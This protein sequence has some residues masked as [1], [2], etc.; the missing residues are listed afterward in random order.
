P[1]RIAGAALW[2]TPEGALWWPDEATL[3]V[4]DLHLEKGS[5]LARRGRLLPPY[6]TA[7]T[8]AT[9]ARLIATL[10]PRRIVCL[11]DS[12]HDADGAGRLDADDAAR[13]RALAAGRDWLWIAGN[14]DA[15][16]LAGIGGRVAEAAA[17]GPLMLRHQAAPAEGEGEI[18]GHFHPKAAVRVGGRRIA[19]RCFVGDGRRLILPAFGAF[20]GGLDVFDPAIATLLAPGFAVWLLGRGRVHHLPSRRLHRS[21]PPAASVRPL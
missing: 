10:A 11:G 16:G 7:A 5:S 4:A 21:A 1:I 19:G 2:A 17:L 3:V 6:D 13:L 18:S 14:H 20:A 15:G 8:L 12:F 9:L